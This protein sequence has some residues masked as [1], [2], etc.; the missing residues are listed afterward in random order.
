MDFN[1]LTQEDKGFIKSLYDSSLQRQQ[2]NQL[3]RDKYSISERT[4]R[5]W[6][7]KLAL[8]NKKYVRESKVLIY[9]LETPRLK[10]WVWWSGKQYVR[11]IIDEPKIMS[12]AW[13]WAGEEEVYDL[14]WDLKTK[15]DEVLVKEF[16]DQFNQADVIVGVNN[17]N[18]DDRWLRARAV[19]YN[20]TMN[21]Y[22]RVIDLM[23]E[24]KRLI[25][26]PSYSLKNLCIHYDVPQRKLEHEGMKMWMM[27]QEGTMKERKEYMEKMIEY[28]RGDILATE[29]LYFRMLPNIRHQVHLGVLNGN[30]KWSCPVCGE[31]ETVRLF[32]TTVTNAG[33]VQHI[34]KCDADQH[35]YKISHSEYLKWLHG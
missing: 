7:A 31:T 4:V 18:F 33:T 3:L 32:K 29:G 13:K 34:M 12:V 21:A 15:D 11:E 26:V 24:A 6:A 1:D 19:K 17:K 22:P 35:Q 23:K 5:R 27:I 30:P 16:V 10:A 28:N 2:I 14:N 9:D 20:V 8:S 25:R